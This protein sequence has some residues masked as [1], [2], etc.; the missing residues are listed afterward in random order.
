MQQKVCMICA[1]LMLVWFAACL[2]PLLQSSDEHPTNQA[3]LCLSA[4]VCMYSG[5]CTMLRCCPCPAGLEMLHLVQQI[6]EAAD[7]DLDTSI[8]S[9]AQHRAMD[10][11][12]V[13]PFDPC[14]LE[15]SPE[16]S[17]KAGTK[18]AKAARAA[19]RLSS[20]ASPNTSGGQ[21]SMDW[22]TATRR[23]ASDGQ[24]GPAVSS[25]AVEPSRKR[26]REREES[27]EASHAPTPDLDEAT[28]RKPLR[29]LR[30][31]VQQ[32]RASNPRLAALRGRGG[33]VATGRQPPKWSWSC[34]CAVLPAA[35]E[36]GGW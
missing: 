18:A 9:L 31:R 14:W 3:N 20:P 28:L 12:L 15:Q 5:S 30:R 19:V 32:T 16:E 11:C 24:P 22:S 25:A 2:R 13:H 23:E 21:S 4:S 17:Q 36:Q 1:L 33:A 10:G 6:Q 26:P 7:T 34:R 27:Y 29:Y 8:H 35:Q